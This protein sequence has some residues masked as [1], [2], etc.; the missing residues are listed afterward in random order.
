MRGHHGR[1]LFLITFVSHDIKYISSYESQSKKFE[2]PLLENGDVLIRNRKYRKMETFQ[3]E[4][5][6]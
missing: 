3:A 2:S 5:M 4:M 1:V 6:N